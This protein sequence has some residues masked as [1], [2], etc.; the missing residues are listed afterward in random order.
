MAR[1]FIC[2]CALILCSVP[3]QSFSPSAVAP[4]LGSALSNSFRPMQISIL[5]GAS[6]DDEEGAA[7]TKD[8]M[9]SEEGANGD[10]SSPPSNGS[11]EFTQD[12]INDMDQL[13]VSLSKES[14]DDKRRKRLAEILDKELADA[15]T[16]DDANSEA[17]IPRFAQLF[18]LSLDSVGQKVQNAAREMALEQQQ[19][20]GTDG[21]DENDTSNESEG[22][23]RIQRVKSPE[24]LQLWGLID[25]MVQSKTRVKLHMGSLGTKA[26]FGEFR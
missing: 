3:S 24:E 14:D 17:E 15:S 13:I 22:G 2:A 19:Q 6:N 5:R 20:N 10:S 12:E 1:F 16:A 4:L 25:M 26:P 21:D 8:A 18:Q 9:G 11:T 23:E 7:L